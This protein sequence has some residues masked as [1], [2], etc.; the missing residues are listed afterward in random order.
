MGRKRAG[1][2]ESMIV[3]MDHDNVVEQDAEKEWGEDVAVG[4]FTDSLFDGSRRKVVVHEFENGPLGRVE[5]RIG[6][7]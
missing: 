5:S 2:A 4:T 7:V 3:V 6:R 1:V